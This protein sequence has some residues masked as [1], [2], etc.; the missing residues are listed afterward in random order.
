MCAVQR[1]TLDRQAQEHVKY[2]RMLATTPSRD[3][4]KRRIGKT[5]CGWVVWVATVLLLLAV[6]ARVGAD[7][8]R[9]LNGAEVFDELSV[10]PS[11]FASIAEH[12][13]SFFEYQNLVLYH[14]SFGYYTTGQVNFL[15]DF[16]T[17]PTLLAPYFGHMVAEQT[18]RM[19]AGMRQARTLREDAP[20]VIAEFGGGNGLL[21]ESILDY[22]N[23]QA[24]VNP[25]VRWRDFH[26][27][28]Q[29]LSVD[30]SQVLLAQQRARNA[31]FGS[32]FEART[33]DA[34]EMSKLFE[35][36]SITGVILSNELI[37]TF[38]VHKV[39]VNATGEPEICYV[40][41]ALSERAWT[42][43]ERRI[44]DPLRRV[45]AAESS[46]VEQMRPAKSK[47]Q[48]WLTRASLTALL[49]T[50]AA[51]PTRQSDVGMIDF[52]EIF[53]P[54]S[55]VPAVA[56]HMARYRSQ[57]SS[58]VA[59]TGQSYVT[60]VNLGIPAFIRG[61]GDAL[62]TGYVMTIDYGGGWREF[63]SRTAR[64]HLRVY[65]PDTLPPVV[66]V[67]PPSAG[68][69]PP[70]LLARVQNLRT[71]ADPYRSPTLNDITTDVNFGL[72]SEEGL[73]AGLR[74]VYFGAQRALRSGTGV[75]LDTPPPM[76]TPA[77]RLDYAFWAR[78]F[79]SNDTFKVL[80]QQKEG[81]DPVY[82]G[83]SP[84]IAPLD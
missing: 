43:L 58:A 74:P 76:Q 72:L 41:P 78:D 28:L 61:A 51:S 26:G 3:I 12:L 45:V 42:R 16:R 30:R 82:N 83:L 48:V 33:G 49:E 37:D 59:R 7:R 11:A 13:P 21:A 31:R 57:Y 56:E 1:P 10:S 22:V 68:D 47:G 84:Q 19:W 67:P 8:R 36:R 81:T 53:V 63:L 29:Y 20:F 64:P 38:G 32:Q 80:V 71:S 44:P 62:N 50:L 75:S 23:R 2:Q 27:Q 39:I 77:Q 69:P 34:T 73:P 4:H 9:L 35:P 5:A 14:P 6:S 70:Q 54:V 79:E 17:F 65:G 25:D 60:Y 66:V 55:V 40:A 15:D 24:S 18:F 52:H 46:I